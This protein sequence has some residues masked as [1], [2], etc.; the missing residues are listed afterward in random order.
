MNFQS[1]NYITYS[2]FCG[3]C[4]IGRTYRATVFHKTQIQTVEGWIKGDFNSLR[5]K[6]IDRVIDRFVGIDGA[7]ETGST[8]TDSLPAGSG[9]ANFQGQR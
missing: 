3:H 8:G 5:G 6:H 1:H 2:L 4:D 7:G 9:F